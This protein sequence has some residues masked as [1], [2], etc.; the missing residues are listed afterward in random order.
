MNGSRIR[1]SKSEPRWMRGGPKL[2]RFARW[3][4]PPE[5]GE[6]FAS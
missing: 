3:V 5:E 4:N 6:A 1:R 2:R